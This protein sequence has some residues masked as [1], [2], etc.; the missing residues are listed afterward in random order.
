MKVTDTTYE[1]TD[2]H[3]NCVVNSSSF[4]IVFKHLDDDGLVVAY[5][6]SNKTDKTLEFF[7]V[8]QA[9]FREFYSTVKKLTYTNFLNFL[10]SS[11]S[12][13]DVTSSTPCP[14]SLPTTAE[15]DTP[16][17]CRASEKQ[18]DVRKSQ[19]GSTSFSDVFYSFIGFALATSLFLSPFI[20]SVF[21]DTLDITS[22]DCR[23]SY[24]LSAN[25][26]VF[27][28]FSDYTC[29]SFLSYMINHLDDISKDKDFD[30]KLREYWSDGQITG[31]ELKQLYEHY[32]RVIDSGDSYIDESEFNQLM[33]NYK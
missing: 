12:N 19:Y 9:S 21:R 25:D 22:Y 4:R 5:R 1:Y 27:S 17:N 33:Q 16:I 24:L 30:T 28:D 11:E 14:S 3:C 6:V 23:A 29:I 2:Y 18:G 32:Q 10:R 8:S 7:E 20:Y 26:R 15:G 31:D 13:D